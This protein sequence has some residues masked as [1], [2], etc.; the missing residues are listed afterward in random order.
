[1]HLI[2]DDLRDSWLDQL[3]AALLAEIERYLGRWA[4]FEAFLG[5]PGV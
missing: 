3:A 1:V 2:A 4:A 5:E